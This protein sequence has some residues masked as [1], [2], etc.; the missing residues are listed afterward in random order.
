[1]DRD[2]AY[3]ILRVSPEA[4]NE[5]IT[6]SYFKLVR[7]YPLEAAPQ[8]FKEIHEAYIFLKGSSQYWLKRL[9]ENTI[10]FRFM[11]KYLP[12]ETQS[13]IENNEKKI[14]Q[15]FER[16]RIEAFKSIWLTFFRHID[17]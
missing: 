9:D 13:E 15:E 3:K 16:N 2:D 4:T 14:Q 1:M 12:K 10:D 5:E 11:N 6:K 7:R 8:R 17:S